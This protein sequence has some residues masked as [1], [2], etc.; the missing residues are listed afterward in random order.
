MLSPRPLGLA[1]LSTLLA[2]V[3]LGSPA[4]HNDASAQIVLKQTHTYGPRISASE[5]R[6]ME[7]EGR[8]REQRARERQEAQRRFS[9]HARRVQEEQRTGRTQLFGNSRSNP[10]HRPVGG[11]TR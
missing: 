4:M 1:I 10:N 5:Q 8:L 2:V 7:A 6:R 9:E 11:A 3:L